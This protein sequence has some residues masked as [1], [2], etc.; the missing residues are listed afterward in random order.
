MYY[1][2]YVICFVVN[3]EKIIERKKIYVKYASYYSTILN[4]KAYRLSLFYVTSN[5]QLKYQN[6]L[7]PPQ[8]KL[9]MSYKS[10]RSIQNVSQSIQTFDCSACS[11]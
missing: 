9:A 4:N 3:G 11:D 6:N 2:E 10:V 5:L 7:L 8:N 1:F